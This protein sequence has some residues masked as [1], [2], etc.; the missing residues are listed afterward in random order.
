MKKKVLYVVTKSEPFGGVQR[1]V[2]DLATSLP[3]DRF[4][5][6]VALGGSGLLKKRLE[7]SGVRTIQIPDLQRDIS[8]SK[9]VSSFLFLL[10]LLKEERP[11]I[12]HLNSSKAGGLGALAGRIR[13]IRT[14]VFTGHGWAFNEA[15]PV[16]QKRI[17]KL[18]HWITILLSHYTV[19][20]SKKTARDVL[21]LPFVESRIRIIYNGLREIPFE[22]KEKARTHFRTISPLLSAFI[23]RKKSRYVLF[24]MTSELHRTKGIDVALTAFREISKERPDVALVIAGQG[25]EKANLETLIQNLGLKERVFLLGPVTDV[26]RYLKAY[27]VFLMPSRTEALPYS[28]IEAGFAGLPIIASKVGGIPEIVKDHESGLLVPPNNPFMLKEAMQEY[29]KNPKVFDLYGTTLKLHVESH[30]TLETMVANTVALY[31][32]ELHGTE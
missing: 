29:L 30:F 1:Y 27:D 26:C 13:G 7:E 11:H 28:V 17:F 23:G 9:E 31:N 21:D 2:F 25:E 3:K 22:T 12:L 4:D 32:G 20:V 8:F 16:M 18:L 15:R 10:R 19:A 5:V 6:V 14:I 24:G